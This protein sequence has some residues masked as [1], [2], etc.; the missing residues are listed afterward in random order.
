MTRIAKPG[1]YD[2]PAEEYHADP[3]ETPSLSASIAR[4]LLD[5]SPLHAWTRHPRLN[6]D[7]EEERKDIFDLGS[8]AH[9]MV[10][11]QNYWREEIEVVDAADW[12]TKAA[13]EARDTARAAGR[14][15]LLT[16][17]Y[18][19]LDKMVRVLEQHPQASRAFT[20]GEPER[21]LVW[22]D[23]ETGVWCRARPDWKP[24]DPATP[25]PDYKTTGDA[26]PETW[27]RRFL[28]DHGG[29]LRAAFYQEGI[30]QV[31]GVENATLCYVVQEIDAPYP[32]TVRV[33]PNGGAEHVIARAMVRKAVHTWAECLRT[34]AW[35]TY[36]LTGVLG[37]GEWARQRLHTEYFEWMEREKTKSDQLEEFVP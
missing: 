16:D 2:I 7:F 29:L 35:P 8:A 15:P 31:C 11:R 20:D 33:F 25:W 9:N 14:Y 18:E 3:V 1:V 30:R 32:I 28:L 37:L 4:V 27:D 24:A 21:S 23:E 10:L 6:P 17:Q 13:R 5:R 19:R 36:D 12:R 26:K 34:G 22:Q